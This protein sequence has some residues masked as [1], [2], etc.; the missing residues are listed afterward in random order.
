MKKLL[1]NFLI[2]S[3][4]LLGNQV[5]AQTT[6]TGVVT[7]EG[8]NEPVIGATVLIKGTSQGTATDLDGKYSLSVD[9]ENAILVFSYTS[10]GDVEMPVNGQTTIDVTM[11][12]GVFDLAEAVV[13]GYGTQKKA[14]VT[15]AIS[16]VKAEDLED[17]PVARIEQSLQG[18]TSGVRVTTTSGQP[19]AGAVVRIRGT[20]TINNS[21]PLYVVDNVPVEGG[22][23]YLNQGDI[24][25]IEVLK[26]AAS[27]AIYGARAANGVILVTTKKGTAGNFSV[28]YNAYYGTQS[29]WKKLSLLN[30]EEYAIIMNEKSVSAGDDILFEDPQSL[31]EGTDW[32]DAVFQTDAP[33]QNHELRISGGTERS[34]V[35][36]SFGYY[37]QEGIVS[38][39]DSKYKRLTARINTNLKVNDWLSF[40]NTFG[41]TR[42]V[43]R[44]VAENTEF[45][46][47]L[48][49]AINIDPL[50][51]VYETD[52]VVLSSAIFTNQPVVQDENGVFGISPRVTSEIVNPLAALEVQQG[53]GHSDKIVGNVFAEIEFLPGLKGKSSFGADLAFWGGEGFTPIHYLNATNQSPKTSY[54]RNQNR[55]LVWLWENTL[56]YN[57]I[58]GSHN[59]SFLL[60]VSGQDN[61]GEGISGAVDN[62]PITS[63]DDASLN[64]P[65][66]AEDEFFGGF[67]YEDK[68]ASYFGKINYNYQEKYLLT[69]IYR[70]DGSSKFGRNNKFANFPGISAGWV[71]TEEDFFQN[72]A[73]LKFLKIRASYG[74]T[75][76]NQINQNLFLAK[77]TGGR[78]YSFGVNDDLINGVAPG[79]ISNPDLKWET[80]KQV[81][82][83]FD[84]R[85]LKNFSLTVDIYSKK[86]E[87]MLLGVEVP[88]LVGNNGLVA[89][90]GTLENKGVEVEL[91]FDKNFNGL[92]VGLS[93]NLSY[94]KNEITFLSN[95]RDH[96]GGAGFGPQGL[97]ISRTTPGFPIGYF[98]GH[99]TDGIFQNWDEVN[100]YTNADGELIQPE[101]APGDFRYVDINGDGKIDEDLDRTQIGDPTPNWTYGFTLGLNYKGFELNMFGQGVWGND[102]FN[103][104]RRFDL[105]MANYTADALGRWTGEGTS[106]T[107]PRITWNDPNKNFNRSSNFFIENG[108]FFRIKTLQLGYHLPVQ[109]LD[110]VGIKKLKVYVSGNNLFTF[111]EYSGFDP[112]IG[113]S[114]GI[115]RG[116]YPQARF[117]L[118]GVNLT[119]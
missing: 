63:I 77:V 16:Q 8:T 108:A 12:A 105:P 6:I 44:G 78:Y 47:P 109:L 28:N 39:N 81:D 103:A 110:K 75:G 119:L 15:G 74:A 46:G 83:G 97:Q 54:N 72:N 23:D 56:T 18:R 82:I 37:D 14:V 19:G 66:S 73:F 3:S 93:G 57:K 69:L 91:G 62:L 67:E 95:D 10:Y 52:P 89:N 113:A 45:G 41:Y 88:A 90:I 51:P 49:R 53:R 76:N 80:T 116:I 70:R 115:D 87:D 65:H 5:F 32:Q 96:L 27:A 114:F 13:T 86:T 11:E 2:I 106:T 34:T 58:I 22:I 43:S 100:S 25:S 64:F 50:T 99:Q 26:D 60:G 17:M 92:S 112:E 1:Y 117:Y 9:D 36:A 33:M 24:E 40:G 94:N 48:N 104:T 118:V 98:I 85:I 107:Y 21:N 38:S 55:G 71:L 31:G 101:A 29:P 4:F 84:A 7:E 30:S 35:F 79:T 111:T 20:T 68:L 61:S 59:F 42:T 102:I